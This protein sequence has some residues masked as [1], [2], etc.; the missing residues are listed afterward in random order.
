LTLFEEVETKKSYYETLGVAETAEAAEIKRAYFGKVRQYQPDRFPGEFKE[1]RAAY[2]TL[3]DPEKRAEYD[4]VGSLPPYAA[5][6]L[7]EAQWFAHAG[8]HNKAA[9]CY[10]DILERYPELDH[11]REQYAWALVSND[12]NGKAMEVWEELCRR[13]PDNP[14][15]LRN[16]G[17]SYYKRG[18]I[19]KALDTAQQAIALDRSSIESWL[20]LVGCV[21][22][23]G[24]GGQDLLDRLRAVSLEALEALRPVK[25]E[26]WKKIPLHVHMVTS[27]GVKN[28]D[29]GR[30]HLR[31]IIRLVREGGR[32]GQDEGRDALKELLDVI[33]FPILGI[34][35]QDLEEL[36][37]LL[38][39]TGDAASL[40]ALNDAR[41]FYDIQS[42]EAKG[43]GVVFHDLLSLLQ[44]GLDEDE[45]KLEI[46]AMELEIIDHR[47][48]YYPQLRR[49]KA[50]FPEL[51][52]LHGA[53]F[54]E[55][56]S[57]RDPEK[58][59]YQREK[60]YNKLKRKTSLV[61]EK[62]EYET[63]QTVHRAE[64]K[65]GR[66]DP[67]PCGSGKKYKRCCGA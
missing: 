59:L 29:A 26:E 63:E 16:L 42:L 6:M 25:N 15:Y 32:N 37:A 31:E 66:N 5:S 8:K 57:A 23:Q 54:K 7:H 61:D 53:F 18:W 34:L 44:F 14:E 28:I 36:V 47:D 35:C 38:P 52:A 19:R 40:K 46:L 30:D 60:Q 2:E 3:A 11:I 24:E 1:I 45:D 62:A 13:N 51:Y 9:E 12:K 41:V 49:L 43:F 27:A 33:P 22:E 48:R 10:R 50:E 17:G 58:M 21:I 20:L 55:A 65:V 67:C 39:D 64:P 4:A 56:M